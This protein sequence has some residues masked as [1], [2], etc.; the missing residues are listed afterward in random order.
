MI[1]LSRLRWAILKRW[2]RISIPIRIR[3]DGLVLGD[4]LTFYGMPIISMEKGS[5][6]SIGKRTVFT[7]H[8]EFTALGVSRPCI[9]R[10][11]SANANISIGK[12][13]GLSGTVICSAKSVVIGK[14]CLFGADVLLADTD[15]HPI[16]PT[17]R[18]FARLDN[19][20]V[21]PIVIGDNVFVGARA[22]ILKG[23]TIGA[24][25]VIGAG[26]LVVSDIPS[27]VVAVGV[28]ARILR[29]LN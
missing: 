4:E 21:E 26:S 19:S 5:S 17:N 14:E 27:G 18:R 20:R 24:N 1:I 6:I 28:P 23:V 10:T 16:E 15:F 9:L 11:L 7:S 29:S 13:T 12:D 2:W 3:R 25:S 8:S 22:I